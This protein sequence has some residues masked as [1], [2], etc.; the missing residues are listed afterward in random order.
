MNTGKTTVMV[1][2]LAVAMLTQGLFTAHAQEKS[3]Y[4]GGEVT[5]TKAPNGA[6]VNA[7]VLEVNSKIL[8]LKPTTEKVADGRGTVS[9]SNVVVPGPFAWTQLRV[10]VPGG[11]G[12]LGSVAMPFNTTT[13]SG[14][15]V[16]VSGPASTAGA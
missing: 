9:L 10:S 12:R 16:S 14:M 7:E 8:Y 11:T 3:R 13:L 6:I 1:A 5:L 15:R 2:A 4:M